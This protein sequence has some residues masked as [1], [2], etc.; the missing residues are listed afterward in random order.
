MVL[1]PAPWA[2]ALTWLARVPASALIRTGA[3]PGD[4]LA[5]ASSSMAARLHFPGRPGDGAARGLAPVRTVRQRRAARSSAHPARAAAIP[6]NQQHPGTPFNGLSA[7]GSPARAL[8]AAGNYG[9]VWLRG[10][11]A[12]LAAVPGQWPTTRSDQPAGLALAD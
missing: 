1:M 12:R 6:R 5:R 9:P 10:D 2:A 4:H 11:Q 3:A 7:Q 8:C